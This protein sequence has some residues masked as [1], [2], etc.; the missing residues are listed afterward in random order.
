MARS[1]RAIRLLH[2]IVPGRLPHAQTFLA[3]SLINCFEELRVSAS[4][5]AEPEWY[6]LHLVPNG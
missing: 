6:P 2:P 1:R 3:T 5:F 4:L